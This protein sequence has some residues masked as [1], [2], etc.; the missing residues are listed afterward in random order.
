MS[1]QTSTCNKETSLD[2]AIE[3]YRQARLELQAIGQEIEQARGKGSPTPEAFIRK[4]ETLQA[5]LAEQRTAL[6]RTL[7]DRL[8]TSLTGGRVVMTAGVQGRGES[9]LARALVAVRSF[10]A[11][12]ADNDPYAEHD[13]GAFEIEGTRLF[14]KIDACAAE[15]RERSVG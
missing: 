3:I 6:T 9:F 4:I 14:W 8:R 11:F 15:A 13:F 5:S 7:N 10:N 1:R 12:D 2:E